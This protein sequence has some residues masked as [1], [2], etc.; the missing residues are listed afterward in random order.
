[1]LR[2]FDDELVEDREIR[3]GGEVFEFIYPHW[4]VGA[5]IFDEELTPAPSEN[6]EPEAFS[7]VADTQ[8]A[9]ER[10]PMFLN[11][12]NDSHKRFKALA[13]RKDD[14]VPR[15]Q[16]AQLYRLLVQVT[17]NLPTT[18]PSSPLSD[19][20]AGA[21]EAGSADVSPSTEETSPA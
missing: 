3:I 8:K 1:M 6:G 11:P 10:I 20:G 4:E 2:N 5:K 14:A 18:P 21:T 12:K 19:D 7:W 15:F 16:F 13:A 9:I 17:S